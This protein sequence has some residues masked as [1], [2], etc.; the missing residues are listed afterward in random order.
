MNKPL[1]LEL[2]EATNELNQ[3]IEQI[4]ANH[5]LPCYLLEYLVSDVLTRLQN[6]K[7]TEIEKARRSYEQKLAERSKDNVEQRSDN[8]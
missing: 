2:E 5:G 6:G 3:A 1:C 8:S 7:R 4:S